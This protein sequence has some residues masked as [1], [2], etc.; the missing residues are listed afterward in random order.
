MWIKFSVWIMQMVWQIFSYSFKFP[1][2]NNITPPEQ[3][4]PLS[5]WTLASMGNSGNVQIRMPEHHP[6]AGRTAPHLIRNRG[7]H[8]LLCLFRLWVSGAGAI[9]MRF[10]NGHFDSMIQFTFLKANTITFSSIDLCNPVN[11]CRLHLFTEEFNLLWNLCD[12]KFT[13]TVQ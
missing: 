9:T 4:S 6:C 7:T 2:K 5:C 1:F 3:P 12:W 8:T 13:R 11:V 10:L